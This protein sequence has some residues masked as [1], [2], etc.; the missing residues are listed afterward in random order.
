MSKVNIV[1]T[2]R[3]SVFVE[4]REI[5]F[6]HDWTVQGAKFAVEHDV[7][8]QLMYDK[9]FKYMIDTGMLYIEDMEEKKALGIEPEEAEE[10]VNV[11]VLTDK[12]RRRYMVN[13]SLDEFKDKVRK[14]SYEQV[15]Q[16]ADYA[17]ANRLAD[18][19]KAEFLKELCGRDIL[20]AI[21]LSAQNKEA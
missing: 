13:L 2:T 1:N 20:Q 17:V 18:F 19:D 21:R 5:P 4:V 9:G 7:L 16:L 15:T 3:G 12:E 14:L 6:R 10:P 8:E 11:I